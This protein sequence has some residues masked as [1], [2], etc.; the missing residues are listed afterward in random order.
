LEN[1]SNNLTNTNS[2]RF[3]NSYQPT[4]NTS[5]TF[6]IKNKKNMSDQ[7]KETSNGNGFSAT[8][9]Q[10]FIASPS[11][12]EAERQII[13]EVLYKWNVLHSREKR[14]VFLPIDWENSSYPESGIHPQKAINKQVLQNADLLIGVFWSRIG[15]ATENYPSG[16]IEEYEEHIKLYKPAM[17]YF[18]KADVPQENI[19]TKQYQLL[20][21][22]KDSCK[23][24]NLYREYNIDEF[25]KLLYENLTN[26]INNNP[27]FTTTVLE[28]QSILSQQSENIEIQLDDVAKEMLITAY[29]TNKDIV[30]LGMQGGIYI[31]PNG[32]NRHS[33]WEQK[34]EIAHYKAALESLETNGL[35]K[36]RGN[37]GEI[38]EITKK[39]YEWIDRK[40]AN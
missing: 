3:R 35:I 37:K 6:L 9:F 26:L 16:S 32:H 34:K 33:D 39:G 7:V 27:H 24:R 2:G 19:E 1:K 17:L 8:V 30:H 10:V 18:S 22:F 11:D 25:E 31:G 29:K 15:T 4:K 40:Y 21:K 5:V 38:F 23:S 36:D 12:V 20:M 14:I 13:R 28:N